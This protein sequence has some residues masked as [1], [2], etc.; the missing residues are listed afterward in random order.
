MSPAEA[1]TEAAGVDIAMPTVEGALDSTAAGGSLKQP[2]LVKAHQVAAVA[3]DS[4]ALLPPAPTT[5]A[6]LGRA[7][8][9][10][11]SGGVLDLTPMQSN[12]F[13]L[14]TRNAAVVSR[15]AKT[16]PPQSNSSIL[17]QPRDPNREMLDLVVAPT[18]PT[19]GA[20]TGAVARS[21][22][23]R[24]GDGAMQKP[25]V[26]PT[27]PK[28]G[29]MMEKTAKQPTS[30]LKNPRYNVQT[31]VS[32][33][34]HGQAPG[35]A[36]PPP[37]GMPGFPQQTAFEGTFRT[38]GDSLGHSKHLTPQAHDAAAVT[39][40]PSTGPHKSVSFAPRIPSETILYSPEIP[41]P[42]PRDAKP[43]SEPYGAPLEV[44]LPHATSAMTRNNTGL[45]T[46]TELDF[47]GVNQIVVNACRETNDRVKVMIDSI[48]ELNV[49]LNTK[50]ADLLVM[51]A[52]MMDFAEEVEGLCDGYEHLLDLLSDAFPEI[53]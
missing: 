50:R 38:P 42:A 44:G 30:I 4:T 34:K 26:T 28:Q 3:T 51:Q 49:F 22:M 53:E 31:N 13:A 47:E 25:H 36:T 32:Q 11:A 23:G 5:A 21:V 43:S 12:E 8:T 17:F 40:G 14:S 37:L 2:S 45:S 46:P 9:P 39:P 41:E 48:L 19:A 1:T 20:Q 6:A 18:V 10:K 52:S 24:N 16:P 35:D 29:Q 33:S 15:P 27:H 7:P